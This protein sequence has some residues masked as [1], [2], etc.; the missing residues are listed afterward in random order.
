MDLSQYTDQQLYEELKKRRKDK[1]NNLIQKEKEKPYSYWK[2]IVVSVIEKSWGTISDRFI[3]TIEDSEGKYN[4][5]LLGNIGFNQSNMPKK[6]DKVLL[7]HK[8]G[9][10]YTCNKQH[11]K[12]IEIIKERL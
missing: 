9:C 11:S 4:A 5:T 3:F 2:G 12:I 1:V 7:R 6:G 10:G 8:I